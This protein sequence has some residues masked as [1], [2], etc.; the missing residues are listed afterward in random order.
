[1]TKFSEAK[2]FYNGES[3]ER[4]LRIGSVMDKRDGRDL[5]R[6]DRR[7]LFAQRLSEQIAEKSARSLVRREKRR[8]DQLRSKIQLST[9]TKTLSLPPETEAACL[10]ILREI[11][12]IRSQ[13]LA[14][15]IGKNE[16]NKIMK[17]HQTRLDDIRKVSP[18]SI[19]A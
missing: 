17:G 6:Q 7:M 13:K 11:E 18:L 16:A 9:E 8:H 1:M 14:G 5:D 15:T 3:V 12:R 19:S 2:V 10:Q 4:Q